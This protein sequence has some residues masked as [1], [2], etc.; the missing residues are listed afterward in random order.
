MDS[1]TSSKNEKMFREKDVSTR[2]IR[3]TITEIHVDKLALFVERWNHDWEIDASIQI[4]DEGIAQY[5]LTDVE[6]HYKYFAA[7]ILQKPS[8]RCR[9]VKEEPRDELEE[10]ENRIHLLGGEKLDNQSH[11]S[12]EYLKNILHKRGYRFE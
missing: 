1:A 5:M 12:V 2:L 4:F 10:Q 7:L 6:S 11:G 9:I 8:L 3:P